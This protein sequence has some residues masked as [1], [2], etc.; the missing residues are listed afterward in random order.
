MGGMVPN[1]PGT[2]SEEGWSATGGEE[3]RRRGDGT[4][5]AGWRVAETRGIPG[6]DCVAPSRRWGVDEARSWRKVGN[7]YVLGRGIG[8]P[9]GE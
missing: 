7:L 2:V 4:C 9:L 8:T 6:L 3:V 1:C 5:V